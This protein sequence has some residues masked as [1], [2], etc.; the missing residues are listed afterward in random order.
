M[1]ARFEPP[2]LPFTS[3]HPL[4][5]RTPTHLKRNKTLT[6]PERHIA[7]VPLITPPAPLG[8]S[9]ILAD[10]PNHSRSWWRIWTLVTTWWAPPA[11]LRL[12][13][14]KERQS[15]QAWREK[16]TLC[17][18]AILLGGVV[19][20]ATMGLQRVLCPEDLSST[21]YD[22]L[23][24]DNCER[25]GLLVRGGRPFSETGM[26]LIAVTLSVNGWVLN[27]SASLV[28]PHVDFYSISTQMPGQDVSNLFVRN[29]TDFP[30]C[31]GFSG[32]FA[33]T[34]LCA[35][36][37]VSGVKEN[38]TLQ[39]CPLPKI[40]DNTLLALQ[41]QNTTLLE[42][43]SWDQVASLDTYMVIDGV[44][45]NM[46]PY[47]AANPTPIPGDDVDMAIRTAL[48][49]DTSSGKDATMLFYNRQDTHDAIPCLQQRYM[50]GRIDKIA[51]GCFVASL[52][53]YAS[54]VVILG[55]VL[56]RFA[57]ACIFNWFISARLVL[58]PKNLSRTAVSPAVMPVG[59]NV[60][61]HN[62]NGT[63][64]W[65]TK[66]S[67]NSKA[68]SSRNAAVG[69]SLPN[70]SSTTLVNSPAQADP[71]INLARIGAEL[72]A[73]ALVTCYSEDEDSVRGTIE[74]IASTNYSDARKLI[75]VVCDGMITGQGEKLSTPD[76]CVGML[77]ADPRFGNPMP[78][79]YIAVGAGA[80]RENR[81]M[82]Y[83]G[84]YGTSTVFRC[85]VH[86]A[87]SRGVARKMLMPSLPERPSHT[88][89]HRR[90]MRDA[91]RGERQE[92]WKSRETRL[93]AHPHELLLE[94]D[95]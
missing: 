62:K 24:A 8:P 33:S 40:S 35:S 55:V 57:M 2:P 6:R 81:A 9:S 87:R 59:A 20:F 22:S 73:V 25:R 31:S 44:V 65:A 84:H 56:V 46:S 93:A 83:A 71:T 75:W 41:I 37:A 72:F 89:H 63:A 90:Q 28:Q 70:S 79:G 61:I 82:V 58:P 43:Y 13:G 77:D 27:I 54:L 39:S 69:K 53:L 80:K 67:P 68:K 94:G 29:L 66:P 45:L 47:I 1:P 30:A 86:R 49:G 91:R 17:W 95:V 38:G 85:L 14:I 64:P 10:S 5:T 21:I 4:P 42:G 76:I 52:F 23:G 92:T 51:P 50:A 19:G 16:I 36:S 12:F 60:S 34:P 3:T 11:V 78:M 7:P 48:T 18:I 32:R 74:S 26:V 15:R 88:N